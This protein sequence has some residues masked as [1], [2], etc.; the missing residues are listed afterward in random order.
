MLFFQ[1]SLLIITFVYFFF[2]KKIWNSNKAGRFFAVLA[3][4]FCLS[5]ISPLILWQ[6]L[7]AGN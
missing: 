4:S 3:S 5:V 2:Q 1:Y 7:L 6:V